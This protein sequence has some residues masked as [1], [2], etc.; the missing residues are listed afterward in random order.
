MT[1]ESP[2]WGTYCVAVPSLDYERTRCDVEAFFGR[3]LAR[4]SSC[5]N[6]EGRSYVVFSFPKQGD[7]AEC[8]LRF[9]GEPFDQRDK[10]R[11]VHWTRCYKG[12]AAKRDRNRDPYDFGRRD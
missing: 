1:W 7:A 11:G 6:H 3:P 2:E 12:R 8:L 5:L 4:Y 10:G 9:S